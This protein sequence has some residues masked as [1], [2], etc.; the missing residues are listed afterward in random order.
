MESEKKFETNPVSIQQI[1]TKFKHLDDIC[2]LVT[3]LETNMI[4]GTCN[5]YNRY[6][7][8]PAM[9][10]LAGVGAVEAAVAAAAVGGVTLRL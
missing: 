1:A 9:V 8:V 2:W 3:G 10:F 6:A 7:T 4:T 5:Q